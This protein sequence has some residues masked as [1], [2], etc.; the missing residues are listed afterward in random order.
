MVSLINDEFRPW[1]SACCYLT[2]KSGARCAELERGLSTPL[3]LYHTWKRQ[4][5]NEC[6]KTVLSGKSPLKGYRKPED[7]RLRIN[8]YHKLFG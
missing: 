7:G 5:R 8:F 6:L 3:S 2:W 1:L 4:T